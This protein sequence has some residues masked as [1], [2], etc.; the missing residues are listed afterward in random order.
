VVLGKPKSAD[1]DGPSSSN[2]EADRQKRLGASYR[3]LKLADAAWDVLPLGRLHDFSARS[4]HPSTRENS[5]AAGD[6]ECPRLLINA[7]SR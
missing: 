4:T 7:S 6:N 3:S 5:L 2:P 1:S